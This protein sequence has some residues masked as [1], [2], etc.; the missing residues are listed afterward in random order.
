MEKEDSNSAVNFYIGSV[1]S[2]GTKMENVHCSPIQ[3]MAVK[4]ADYGD[5]N[6][7]SV[8]NDVE[9]IDRTCSALTNCQV[10]SRCGGKRSCELTMNRK[11]LPSQYCSDTSK[12]IYT[13]YTC[14]DSNSSTII[15]AGKEHVLKYINI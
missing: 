8:S 10:K 5:F 12:K 4:S 13:K 7:N 9:N 3:H 2:Y 15:T 1:T 6:K 11:L 14:V